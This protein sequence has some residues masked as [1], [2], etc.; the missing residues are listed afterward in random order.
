MKKRDALKPYINT[1]VDASAL[2][3]ALQQDLELVA[4]AYATTQT[5]LI[6]LEKA[7]ARIDSIAAQ[8]GSG[9][10]VKAFRDIA[11]AHKDLAA[12][13]IALRTEGRATIQARLA[14]TPPAPESEQAGIGPT[15]PAKISSSRATPSNTENNAEIES[16]S[17]PAANTPQNNPESLEIA[18]KRPGS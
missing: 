4:D 14:A 12:T 16:D 10:A 17:A 6:E 8:E 1:Q 15:P 9:A 18:Q 5:T 7:Y 3:T 11:A 13:L 2:S